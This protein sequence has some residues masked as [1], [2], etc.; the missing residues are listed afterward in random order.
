MIYP[1]CMHVLKN[2]PRAGQFCRQLAMPHDPTRCARHDPTGRL[3]L[4]RSKQ[5]EIRR[6]GAPRIGGEGEP[7]VRPGHIRYIGRYLCIRVTKVRTDK[8]GW[9]VS[10]V[11]HDWRPEFRN[12]RRTP[13]DHIDYDAVREAY[14]P[15]VFQWDKLPVIETRDRRDP[16]EDSAYAESSIGLVTDA[17]EGVSAQVLEDIVSGRLDERLRK[18]RAAIEKAIEAQRELVAAFSKSESTSRERKHVKEISHHVDQLVEQLDAGP[19][20]EAA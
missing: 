2:G 7:P 6:G 9:W 3:T 12:L 15:E 4:S 8:D 10:Y 18:K 16:S 14:A 1:K 13:A 20:T 19:L 17:G 5:E 11:V